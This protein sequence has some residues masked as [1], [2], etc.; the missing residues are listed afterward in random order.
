M[1]IAMFSSKE[2]SEE[3]LRHIISK[4][5]DSVN[6]MQI[7]LAKTGDIIVYPLDYPGSISTF[8]RVLSISDAAVF[9]LNQEVSAL[10]AEI[11]LAL[12]YSHITAGFVFADDYSDVQS[13]DTLFSKYKIG[14]FSKI[15]E[16][17]KITLVPSNITESK[18][19]IDKHFIVKG[20]GQVVLGFVL[21]GKIKKSDKMYLVP[22]GKQVTVKSIQVMDQDRESC[23]TGEHVGLALNNV[24][25]K[26][27]DLNYEISSSNAV[28][29]E[30]DC[31]FTKTDFY[32]L[33]PFGSSVMTCAV[34]GR[35]FGLSL[36]KDGES[37]KVSFSKPILPKQESIVVADT[38]LAV[39]KNRIVGAVLLR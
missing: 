30:F 5:L 27:F 33:D 20:I 34:D 37:V 18:V 21:G 28:K 19:S 8:L 39:G 25:E 14:K 31:A 6:N 23:E 11:A 13:F 7:A 2:L 15:G 35:N 16:M 12:E 32:K 1:I 24:D 17:D 36:K 26:D 9:V 22:S 4:K 38:S 10:D 3:K 29:S